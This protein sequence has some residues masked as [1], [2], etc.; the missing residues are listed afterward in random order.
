MVLAVSKAV[1]CA[2]KGVFDAMKIEHERWV[3]KC[4]TKSNISYSNPRLVDFVIG[5][6]LFCGI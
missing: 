2:R 5:C 3:G 6:D 4:L 1:I